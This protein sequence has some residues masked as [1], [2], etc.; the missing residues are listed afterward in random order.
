MYHMR[1]AVMTEQ[2]TLAP[3]DVPDPAPG[4]GEVLLEVTRCGICGSDLH[5][6]DMP[7]RFGTGCIIGHEIG[8]VVSQIGPGVGGW[9]RG[10]RVAAYHSVSCGSCANCLAGD[11]YMCTRAALLSLGL[12]AVP[13]GYAESIVVPVK[14]L[15]RVPDS[16]SDEEAALAEPLAIGMHGVVKAGVDPSVP[17]VVLGAGP[18]GAMSALALRFAGHEKIVLVEPNEYRRALMERLG[19][20][21]VGLD[22]VAAAVDAALGARPGAVLECSG[23]GRAAQLAIDLVGYRGRV[24]LQGR[25]SRPVE[26]SQATVLIKEVEL[27][28]AVSCT[29]P[30]FAEAIGH[31]AAGRVPTK[32]LVTATVGLAGVNDMF[33]E[34]L[35]PGNAHLKVLVDPRA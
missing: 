28:G 34:L 11:E 35:S 17:T 24:V 27:V 14:T 12:G 3:M 16:V 8:G 23:N 19:F 10:D 26:I 2:R 29:E 7:E 13:G 4:A 25:P 30:E 33:D 5:M 6:R 31:L 9:Q 1:A 20:R 15:F 18:I 32:D 21:A 22:D